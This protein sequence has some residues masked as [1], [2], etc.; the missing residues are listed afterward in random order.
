MSVLKINYH[1]GDQIT[2]DTLFALSHGSPNLTYLCLTYSPVSDAAV[3]AL[4]NG[5]PALTFINLID[6]QAISRVV[7][8]ELSQVRPSLTISFSFY[9]VDE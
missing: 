5:C 4:C 9:S 3:L 6:I 1:Q 2:D 7:L 8:E